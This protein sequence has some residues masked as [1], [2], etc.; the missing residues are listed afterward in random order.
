MID[1]RQ[2]WL[3][4]LIGY[5]VEATL[6]SSLKK[7]EKEFREQ[8]CM[9]STKTIH[10]AVFFLCYICITVKSSSNNGLYLS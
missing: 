3:S 8:V 7:K 5:L 2:Q 4:G 9:F 10:V 1:F 6:M